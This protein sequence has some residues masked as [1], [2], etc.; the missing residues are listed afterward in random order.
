[1]LSDDSLRQR[2]LSA[3][4]APRACHPLIDKD[5]TAHFFFTGRVAEA[6]EMMLALYVHARHRGY[7]ADVRRSDFVDGSAA[8]RCASVLV[9][10][11]TA[12]CFVDGRVADDVKCAH[13]NDVKVL[14][15]YDPDVRVDEVLERAPPALKFLRTLRWKR[16]LLWAY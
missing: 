15:V 12:D 4:A 11:L 1:M 14:G 8:V 9:I 6:E 7:E 2:Q 13:R 5:K 3:A 10:M 16:D